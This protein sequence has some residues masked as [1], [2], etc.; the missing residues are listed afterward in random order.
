M[1]TL[2]LNDMYLASWVYMFFYHYRSIPQ[3]STHQRSCKKEALTVIYSGGTTTG[4]PCHRCREDWGTV[5]GP[6]GE[7][8]P[9]HEQGHV[10]PIQLCP[11]WVIVSLVTLASDLCILHESHPFSPATL[12]CGS[13]VLVMP[14]FFTLLH[15]LHRMSKSL[16]N[17]SSTEILP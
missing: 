6:S 13:E 17:Y 12:S 9:H 1:F 3:A 8:L 10:H 5:W 11:T 7:L 16:C 14:L 2:H 15:M 4:C